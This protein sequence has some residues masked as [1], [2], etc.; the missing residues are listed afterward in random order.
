MQWGFL[1]NGGGASPQ[2]D[3]LLSQWDCSLV[4]LGFGCALTYSEQEIE[5]DDDEVSYCFEL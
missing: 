3:V 5:G 2:V 1:G 4:G